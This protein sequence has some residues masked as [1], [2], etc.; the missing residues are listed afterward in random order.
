M[1]EARTAVSTDL[2]VSLPPSLLGY[3]SVDEQTSAQLFDE[4]SAHPVGNGVIGQSEMKIVDDDGGYD[5][6]SDHYHREEEVLA[7]ER[8]AK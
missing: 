4:K 8:N 1:H 2:P 5:R 3:S 7:D 6:R